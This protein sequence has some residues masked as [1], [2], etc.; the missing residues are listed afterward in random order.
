MQ[1]GL[2]WREI[3]EGLDLVRDIPTNWSK[4]LGQGFSLD[5]RSKGLEYSSS[6]WTFTKKLALLVKS[7]DAGA[8]REL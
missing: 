2:P 3:S 4:E 5:F 1:G 7:R 8:P 6:T